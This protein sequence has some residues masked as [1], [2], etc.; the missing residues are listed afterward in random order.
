MNKQLNVPFKV[1][2]SVALL[3]VVGCISTSTPS[4]QGNWVTTIT[5][6]DS[7][8]AGEGGLY[9]GGMPGN[10]VAHRPRPMHHAK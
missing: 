5:E 7:I 1:F 2:A 9:L 8:S 4:L 3:F 10:A 6:A